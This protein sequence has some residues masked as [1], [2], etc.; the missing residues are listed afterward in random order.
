MGLYGEI[1]N[2]DQFV[3]LFKYETNE[4]KNYISLA[5]TMLPKVKVDT[6]LYDYV[7]RLCAEKKVDGHRADIGIIKTAKTYS[8]FE[9]KEELEF[10][11]IV[12]AAKFVLGHRTREGGLS[13]PL[14]ESEIEDFFRSVKLN[15]RQQMKHKVSDIINKDI[16][17]FSDGKYFRLEK[18]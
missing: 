9:L 8:A 16:N 11:H 4:L 10:R 18:K 5:R 7:T 15:K 1:R 2:P 3:K 12:Q 14:S 17:F 13:K 6:S